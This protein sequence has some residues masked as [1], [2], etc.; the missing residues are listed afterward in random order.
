M[1]CGSLFVEKS[2]YKENVIFWLTF[3]T[4]KISFWKFDEKKMLLRIVYN[5]KSLYNHLIFYSQ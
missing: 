1:F 2:I 3:G 4:F 5:L